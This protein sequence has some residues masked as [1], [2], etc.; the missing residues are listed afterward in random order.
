MAACLLLLAALAPVASAQTASFEPPPPPG[1]NDACTASQKEKGPPLVLVHGTF[2]N[3]FQNWFKFSPQLEAA[4]YCVF[5]LNYGDC[6][7]FGSCGRGRI[8]ESA[9]ELKTFIESDRNGDGVRDGGVL[10]ESLSGKVSILGHSQGGLMPRY[11]IKLLDGAGKVDDMVSLSASNHGTD[12]PLAGPAGDSADC[13]ACA[14]Q[15]PYLT[16]EIPRQVNADEETP[17][18]VDY[19]QVQTFFDDVVLPYFSAF[20]AEE[21]TDNGPETVRL[22][23]PS[24]TNFCLQDA[25]PANTDDHLSI[26]YSDQA[27]LV[28][29]DALDKQGDPA[30][31][32]ALPDAVCAR[33]AAGDPR[34]GGNRDGAGDEGGSGD[35]GG[36]E[37]GGRD[38]SASPETQPGPPRSLAL[39]EGFARYDCS[40]LFFRQNFT[41]FGGRR[42]RRCVTAVTRSLRFDVPE[43]LSCR[44]A[45]LSRSRVRGHRRSDHRACVLAARRALRARDLLL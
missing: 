24:T 21:G 9:E 1:A 34:T 6:N 31:P 39:L 5:A 42:F 40:P 12:N 26:P 30:A 23:G 25:F 2:E 10:V 45:G 41:P 4:G 18:D 8:E 36:D 19:T 3:R 38:D 14:Q 35:R 16:A 7:E 33:L 29:L 43:E 32:P 20:L 37:G 15:V 11:Y 17:G 44:T 22:N 13:P 27:L 28:V